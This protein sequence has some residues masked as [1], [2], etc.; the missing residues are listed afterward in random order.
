MSHL[1]FS[2]STEMNV[3]LGDS[4]LDFYSKCK[5]IIIKYNSKFLFVKYI[6]SFQIFKS[7]ILN[8]SV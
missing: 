8:N 5:S 7:C 3:F 4:V 2:I 6:L 1:L